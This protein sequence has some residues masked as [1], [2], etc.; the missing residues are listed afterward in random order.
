M[1][2]LSWDGSAV[3]T[4]TLRLSTVDDVV[5]AIERRDVPGGSA[6]GVAGALAVLLS[7]IA[8]RDV[9]ADAGRVLAARR[10]DPA[11]R[12]SVARMLARLPDGV[13]A[14]LDEA[15]AVVVEHE[16]V[17]GAAAGRAAD[18]VLRLTT[19]RPLRLR[20]HGDPARTTAARGAVHVLGAAGVLGD[21]GPFPGGIDCLLV[22]AERV[23]ARG[24]VLTAAGGHALAAAARTADVPVVAVTVESTVDTED[25]VRTSGREPV[26][27]HLVTAVVTED[28]VRRPSERSPR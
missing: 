9:P 22:D 5:T 15:L 21:A 6:T 1:R 7:A 27:A 19:R 14:V 11:L 24:A 16:Q 23:S 18:L 8:D 2:T 10:D 3:V 28:G 4:P 17:T 25:P 20:V 12:R 26:P 13:A